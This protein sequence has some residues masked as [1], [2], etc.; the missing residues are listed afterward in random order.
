MTLYKDEKEKKEKKQIIE[1]TQ[2]IENKLETVNHKINN[3][4]KQIHKLT[5]F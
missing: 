2:V 5:R 1:S 4:Y 3:T